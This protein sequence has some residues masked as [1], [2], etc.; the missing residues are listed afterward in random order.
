MERPARVQ[1]Q[2]WAGRYSYDC[3]VIGE[4]AKRYRVVYDFNLWRNHR[5]T[6]AGKPVLVPKHA[7]EFTDQPA[8]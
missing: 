7:V 3:K 8:R 1:F 6:E 5:Y 2:G 4:T